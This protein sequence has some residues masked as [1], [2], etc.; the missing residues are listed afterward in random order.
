MI[1]LIEIFV[2]LIEKMF[3]YKFTDTLEFGKKE[4]PF[5]KK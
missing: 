5:F 2:S 4:A 1:I 3:V